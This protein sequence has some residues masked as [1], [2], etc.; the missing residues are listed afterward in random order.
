MGLEDVV[1]CPTMLSMY[2]VHI[3]HLDIPL[4]QMDEHLGG[5]MLSVVLPSCPCTLILNKVSDIYPF[6]AEM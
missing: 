3:V 6:E 5:R 1:C 4:H 2:S